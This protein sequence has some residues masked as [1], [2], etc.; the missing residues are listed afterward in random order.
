MRIPYTL[1]PGTAAFTPKYSLLF[2]YDENTKPKIKI[3]EPELSGVPEYMNQART[4]YLV[5]D[6]PQ[7][8]HQLLKSGKIDS[9]TVAKF[10]EEHPFRVDSSAHHT[11]RS[12]MA[13]VVGT[14]K[15]GQ[16]IARFDSNYDGDVSDEMDY[17]ISPLQT[18]EPLALSLDDALSFP[19]EFV[20][21]GR[22]SE[23]NIP[24][25]LKTNTHGDSIYYAAASHGKAHLFDHE[26]SLNLGFSFDPSL[27][28]PELLIT[29]E[30][31]PVGGIKK[32]GDLLRIG[33][34]F[35]RYQGVDPIQQHIRLERVTIPYSFWSKDSS[36]YAP[37]F[38]GVE[39]ST[40]KQISLT[41]LQGKYVFLNF[42]G[43]WCGPCMAKIPSI[44]QA[45]KELENENVVFLGIASESQKGFAKVLDKR[46]IDWPQILSDSTNE[47]VEKFNIS[48]YP[49]TMLLGPD[50]KIIDVNLDEHTLAQAIRQYME[51]YNLALE[52]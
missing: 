26:L 30:N 24:I 36:H 43:T 13:L 2:E 18:N 17:V 31:G 3:G 38:E 40:N 15:T 6:Y 19:F 41:D 39:F 48:S 10:K 1:E 33:K 25:I 4:S 27:S 14:T 32:D 44:V 51:L 50:G 21:D 11:T 42:W 5:V 34:R 12:Y 22:L 8:L 52:E 46:Q 35:Y 37:Y 7:F 9:T 16:R 23:K 45:F 28:N 20:V 47:I 29:N 49:T